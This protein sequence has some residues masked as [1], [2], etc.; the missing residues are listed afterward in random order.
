GSSMGPLHDG[1]IKPDVIAPGTDI[2]STGFAANELQWIFFTGVTPTMGSFTLTF[3][4]NVTNNIAFNASNVTLQTELENLANI[5]PGD[6]TIS[7]GPLPNAVRIEFTGAFALTNVANMTT[8][9]NGL[10]AGA[11]SNIWPVDGYDDRDGYHQMGGT[12]MSA[13]VIAG[14]IA[15]L[16]QQWQITYSTPLGT[17]I[18]EN[19][20]YPSTLRAVIIQT[21]DDIVNPNIRGVGEDCADVD[22]DNNFGNGN[23]GAGDA[24]ATDGPD[25]AT[26]WGMLNAIDALELIQDHRTVNGLP[27]PNRIIQDAVDQNG[28]RSYDFVVN[29]VGPLRVTLAWDDI[30]GTIQNPA[31]T[32]VLVNDL[33][34]VLVAPDN[35]VFYPWQ[36]GH[37]IVDN[38][39]VAIANVAQLPGT[40]ITVDVPITPS[41]N[42][43]AVDDYVPANALAV[44]GDWVA[45][46]GRDHLNNV[47]QVFIPNVNAAQVGHWT[48]RV[49]GF[50]IQEGAQ[51]FSLVGFPYPDLAELEVFCSD[52]VAIADYDTDISFTWTV[53]NNGEIATGP[54]GTTFNYRVLLSKDFYIG[55]DVVLLD[56]ALGPL[57]VGE[58][59]DHESTIQISQANADA[60]TGTGGTSIDNLLEQ[61]VFIIIQVDHDNN[62]LEH[63]ETNIA[64]V[65]LARVVDVTIVLDRSGSMKSEVPV[66]SGEQKKIDI[67]K[68]SANLFLD[69][70][71]LDA[72]DR[73]AQ[74]SFAGDLG[75]QSITIDFGPTDQL[76]DIGSGNITDAKD[77]VDGLDAGGNTDIRGALQQGL[78][79]LT[80]DGANE[81]RKVLVFFS[82]GKKTAGGDPSEDAFLQQ[83]DDNNVYVYSVGFGTEGASGN[84]GI[85]IELLQLLSNSAEHSFF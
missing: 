53:T 17:T 18:D 2:I 28:D 38:A 82:D 47:E 59:I 3:N 70:M 20:P 44:G 9:D 50:N 32:P 68:S 16:L 58:S 8:V 52:R 24:T 84:S 54:A 11:N 76:T 42:P 14:T 33:D 56:A 61:D 66:S 35:T 67:L 73:T 55:D 64:V 21:V 62:V 15:N 85:D 1:R 12:S 30:E 48:A 19:P 46:Q 13:P 43:A 26:G 6:I 34:I 40:P 41:V 10:D 29:A 77:A 65:Q 39:G 63:R 7:R 31:T 83:F 27:V 74:V 23:N 78:D 36:L 51:D 57:D 49:T 5:S 72:G 4:G 79:L 25:Y 71:R 22:S 80:A 75:L 37:T 69:L 45:R 60:L 81:R